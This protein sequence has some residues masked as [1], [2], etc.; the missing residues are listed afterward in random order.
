MRASRREEA[1]YTL[2]QIAGGLLFFLSPP[3]S[4]A[5]ADV[6]PLWRTGTA[7][8]WAL[9][10]VAITGLLFTLWARM[11]LGR[12]WSASVTRKKGHEFVASGPYAIVR[13]PIYT[14]VM[15]A[16]FA[17]AIS[18]GTVPGWLGALLI[19]YGF[20]IKARLEERFLREEF[21]AE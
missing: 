20:W 1:G 9:V 18:M 16:L 5:S 6:P 21:G 12:N 14:G 17:T 2:L 3:A 4:P 8:G 19:M 7:L 13:H 11:E 10:A 15:V